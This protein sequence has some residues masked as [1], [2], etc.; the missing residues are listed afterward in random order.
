MNRIQLLFQFEIVDSYEQYDASRFPL[1][2]S[3]LFQPTVDSP[4]PKDEVKTP[5]PADPTE[6]AESEP[7]AEETEEGRRIP[8]LRSRSGS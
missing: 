8:T 7:A 4:P 1:T 6:A 5:D 3:F 2:L